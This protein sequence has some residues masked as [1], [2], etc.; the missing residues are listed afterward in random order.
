MY[1]NQLRSNEWA[2]LA[3]RCQRVVDGNDDQR[4]AYPDRTGGCQSYKVIV[5]SYC[6][7]LTE[8]MMSREDAPK[9]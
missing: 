6:F 9:F 1:M 8:D 4:V 5:R 3:Y 2:G 7:W